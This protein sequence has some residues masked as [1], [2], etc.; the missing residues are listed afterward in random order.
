MSNSVFSFFLIF[1]SSVSV[2]GLISSAAP[3]RQSGRLCSEQRD[4]NIS[5]EAYKRNAHEVIHLFFSL[6]TQLDD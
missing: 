5:V 2:S 3:D 1:H 6:P 4:K